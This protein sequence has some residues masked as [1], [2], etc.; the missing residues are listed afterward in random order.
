MSTS[1]K[2]ICIC[3]H[4][5]ICKRVASGANSPLSSKTHIQISIHPIHATAAIHSYSDLEEAKGWC[6]LGNGQ[7]ECCSM[8]QMFS[9]Q[10]QVPQLSIMPKQVG[11]L[12]D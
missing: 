11:L 2:S 7:G 1:G 10:E 4:R 6:R 5:L 9:K 8:H 3:L 12:G